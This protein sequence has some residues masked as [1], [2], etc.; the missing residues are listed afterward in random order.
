LTQENK[1][2]KATRRRREKERKEGRAAQSKDVVIV[3]SLL[4]GFFVIKLFVPYA[5]AMIRN[6]CVDVFGNLGKMTGSTFEGRSDLFFK[7]LFV[8][9]MIASP[10]LLIIA[11]FSI[12]LTGL[13]TKFLISKKAIA[14]KFSHLNPLKGFK[15]MF[16]MKSLLKLF[17]ESLKIFLVGF[18]LYKAY[19]RSAESFAKL[20]NVDPRSGML[21]FANEV[22]KIVF[23]LGLVLLAIAAVDYLYNWW[24]YEKSIRMTKQEIKDE[25]KEIEGDPQIKGYIKRRQREIAR[26]RMMQMVPKA[27]VVIRNPTHCAVALKYDQ[28]KNSAPVVI[29]KGEDN[30]ALKIIQVAEK[31]KVPITE[32]KWLARK[33]CKTKL[34]KTIPSETFKAVA[35]ILLW[36]YNLKK[37][38]FGYS[39]K[40]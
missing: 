4:A 7:G 23:N 22:I 11:V 18:V 20:M 37:K 2:E 1:T 19:Q 6:L 30:I 33:L 15:N 35:E 40:V 25:Y 27:D 28:N 38:E 9:F 36:V 31:N 14:F 3:G 24:S 32:N 5:V 10:I 17:M 12:L 34:N 21:F 39:E 13:Q 8:F 16:S 26:H 29:A